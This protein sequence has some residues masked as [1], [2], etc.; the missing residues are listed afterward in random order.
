VRPPSA[1]PVALPQFL[2]DHSR[3]LI[4]IPIRI[5]SIIVVAL[6][7][8][9]ILFRLIKRVTR[10]VNAAKMPRFLQ[11]VRER[12]S[13]SGLLESAGLRSE[14]RVQRAATL[15]SVLRSCVSITVF[16]IA[17]L[18]VLSEVKIDLAPFIAGTSIVGIA[19][20]FGAQ[21]VIKDYLSGL[22]ML[23]EDQ[24]GVGDVIDFEKA[25]G[26][27]EAV[28]LRTTTLRDARGTVWYVRNG[29]VVRV[30]NQSQG[31]ARVVLD[32]P[33][34]AHAD[35]EAATAL[36]QSVG[37]AVFADPTWHAS[38]LDEPRVE[39]IESMTLDQTM[40]RLVARVRPA[41]H[42]PVAREL[43]R[44]IRAGLDQ[45]RPAGDPDVASAAAARQRRQE[46]AERAKRLDADR[47]EP[48]DSPEPDPPSA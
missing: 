39:G 40:I 23:F 7:I 1:T 26:T 15:A 47:P 6:I 2:H 21:N 36:M 28:G 10:P 33:V 9:A 45:L 25:T 22:L 4:E 42:A 46:Q 32:I 14:R 17:F 48:T 18:L 27:V 3:V 29:E 31:Y 11:P 30:G 43:R 12:V 24:Y 13:S 44:R 20:A 37:M 8:R 41:D 5:V 19:V 16:S 38:F 34:D 35:V